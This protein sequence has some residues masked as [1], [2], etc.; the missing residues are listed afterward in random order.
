MIVLDTS[1]LIDVLRGDAA[2]VRFASSLKEVP[3]CS[4]V[5]RV[6]VLRGLRTQERRPAERLFATLRWIPLDEAVA[7]QAGEFGRALR[8]SH[9]SVSTADLIVAATAEM[10]GA[11]LAT[12]NVRDFPM[13][14][15][16]RAPY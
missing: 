13:F 7:R 2:A 12:M 9:R 10:V 1:V 6:E 4:E 16:L 5:T 8:A 3:A 14:K 11:R 15:G